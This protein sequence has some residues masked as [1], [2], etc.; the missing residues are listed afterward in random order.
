MIKEVIKMKYCVLKNT[1]QILDGS[2][3]PSEVMIQNAINAGFSEKEVE[4]L[5]EEEYEARKA[6]EPPK[7]KQLSEIDKLRIE[8]AQANA[9]LF[10][11]ILMM[12]GGGL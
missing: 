9:E 11:M 12:T 10:E 1:T 4:I 8:Q 5:T 6:L 7:P 3:N 2:K